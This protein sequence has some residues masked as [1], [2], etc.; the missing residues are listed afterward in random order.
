MKYFN[1]TNQCYRAVHWLITL[2]TVLSIS[3][4]STAF[5]ESLSTDDLISSLQS[6][7]YI[8]Y[9]RHGPTDQSQKDS[10][11]PD[12]NDCKTQRNISDSGYV[13][14]EEIA[15]KIKALNIP[16]GDVYSSPYCRC[17]ETAKIVFGDYTVEPDLAFSLTKSEKESRYLGNQLYKMMFSA[18]SNNKNTVFVGH[19]ANLKEGLG[20]WPKPESVVVLF[21]KVNNQIVYQGMILPTDWPN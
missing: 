18:P 5:A 7:G 21:R 3:Y 13:E 2:A 17:Q 19:T 9:M 14:L 6:G 4:S 20:I 10:I 1:I 12:F 8:I 15:S 11:N 16:V